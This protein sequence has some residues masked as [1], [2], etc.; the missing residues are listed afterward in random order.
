MDFESLKSNH[1]LHA[2]GIGLVTAY[3]SKNKVLGTGVGLGLYYYMTQYGHGFG[4]GF[5][6]CISG[7]P[8]QN[9]SKEVNETVYNNPRELMNTYSATI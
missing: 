5:G 8:L 6:H 1:L 7:C 3:A 9:H 2:V 4:H